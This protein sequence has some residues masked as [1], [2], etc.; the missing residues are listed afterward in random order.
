MN[1][2][3]K[4]IYERKEIDPANFKEV[5]TVEL[6][7]EVANKEID[8]FLLSKYKI[9]RS[10]KI[11]SCQRKE[12]EWTAFPPL[13]GGLNI[14][15]REKAKKLGFIE[16][17][18]YRGEKLINSVLIDEAS[19]KIK[20]NVDYK[21]ENVNLKEI[22]K[23]YFRG[24]EVLLD[25]QIFTY[26]K[27]NKIV[28]TKRISEID[29]HSKITIETDFDI[30]DTGLVNEKRVENITTIGESI[31]SYTSKEAIKYNSHRQIEA[32]IKIVKFD[33]Q[34]MT[35]DTT[36]K[37]LCNEM[38]LISEIRTIEG[39]ADPTI[40]EYMYDENKGLICVKIENSGNA[41]K[42]LYHRKKAKI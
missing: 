42:T 10:G 38:D 23:S 27:D 34:E 8:S 3:D 25:K 30:D 14:G 5:G 36:F 41:T 1:T 33:G 35:V 15:D 12:F 31:I 37:Y 11:Q 16:R 32:T 6:N 19:Q 18:E 17:F 2:T 13:N 28:K 29:K 4:Y 7:L 21:Y 24:E 39:D 26:D 9:N 20:S 40:L 22:T